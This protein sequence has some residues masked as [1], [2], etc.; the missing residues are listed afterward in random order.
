MFLTISFC[1]SLIATFHD[2]WNDIHSIILKLRWRGITLIRRWIANSRVLKKNG[3]ATFVRF[4]TFER[5]IFRPRKKE[6]KTWPNRLISVDRQRLES[7]LSRFPAT[8]RAP[9]IWDTR[10]IEINLVERDKVER[11][12]IVGRGRRIVIVAPSSLL[13]ESSPRA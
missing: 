9:K 11:S 12:R 2:C 4:C 1:Y 6:K 3:R 8:Y 5:R 7:S 10:L 13:D